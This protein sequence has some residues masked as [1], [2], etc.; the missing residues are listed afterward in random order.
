MSSVRSSVEGAFVCE[1]TI[2]AVVNRS[3]FA[4]RAGSGLRSSHDATSA[5]ANKRRTARTFDLTVVWTTVSDKAYPQHELRA[6]MMITRSAGG[7]F[8]FETYR[9]R[10]VDEDARWSAEQ[11]D[12]LTTL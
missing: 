11:E 4:G 10:W 3:F 7:I 5:V 8:E 9:M 2:A 1:R 6:G 12:E